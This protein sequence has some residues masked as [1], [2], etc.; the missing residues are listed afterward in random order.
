MS[1]DQLDDSSIVTARPDSPASAVGGETVILSLKTDN[2]FGL[3]TVG[4]TVWEYV[5]QPRQ[6]DEICQEIES[7]YEVESERCRLDLQRLLIQMEE[8]GLVTIS[9]NE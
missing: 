6:F 8:N 1:S 7:T 4:T 3:N 9:R 2:Y 5:Q